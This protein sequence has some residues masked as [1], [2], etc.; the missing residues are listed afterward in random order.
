MLTLF[1]YKE[2]LPSFPDHERF[3]LANQLKRS[4]YSIP[5]NIAESCGRNSDKDFVHF[6]D[7]SLGSLNEVSYTLL[8]AKDLE[9][10]SSELYLTALEKQNIVKAKLI[11]LI[12]AIRV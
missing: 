9:Y 7:V 5:M 6:L 11:K 10:L 1:V 3:A 12:K 2:V 8:L 4:A